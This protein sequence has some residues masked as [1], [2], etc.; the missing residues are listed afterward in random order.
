[1]TKK[2][3][4]LY[5]EICNWSMIT[6]DYSQMNKIEYTP[7]QKNIPFYDQEQKKTI[8]TDPKKRKEKIKCLNC[9]RL[10]KIKLI[11]DIKEEKKY[12][13]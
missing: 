10:V 3:Y 2:T 8:E 5:C 11:E 12:Q 13:W 6:E 7:I 9:G 1:M 4:K